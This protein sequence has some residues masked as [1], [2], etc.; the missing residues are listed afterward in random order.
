L[1]QRLFDRM[2]GAG[3]ASSKVSRSYQR[4][5]RV[6]RDRCSSA[7]SLARKRNREKDFLF[8]VPSGPVDT[9]L[10]RIRNALSR[11]RFN[12]WSLASAA[13]CWS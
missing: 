11:E 5:L 2:R 4:V 3:L 9:T 1:P 7:I 8:T 13:A 10:Q 12:Y 6:G